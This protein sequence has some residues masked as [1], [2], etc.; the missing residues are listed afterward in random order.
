M[1]D[2]GFWLLVFATLAA[3]FAAGITVALIYLA[4]KRDREV[5]DPMWSDFFASG[6]DYR[7]HRRAFRS[8]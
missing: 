3:G 2:P 1:S 8:H 4:D 6:V 7:R 5:V